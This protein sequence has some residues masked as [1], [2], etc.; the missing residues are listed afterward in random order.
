MYHH[1]NHFFRSIIGRLFYGWWIVI[2][3]ALIQAVGSGILYH[4][5]TVFFLPWKREFGASSVVISF[6][7]GA[8][9]LEGG[10]EG[11]AVGYLIDRFGPRALII[12]GAGLAGGGLILISRVQS[13]TAL[14]LIYVLVVSIGYNAGFLHPIS[15]AINSWFVRRRAIGFAIISAAGNLGGMIMAP[16]LSYILLN[17]GWRDGTL[18]AGVLI[19][20][21][22]LPSALLIH[23]SPE[24]RGLC[25]DGDAPK[26]NSA[27][28]TETPMFINQIRPV[29]EIGVKQAIKNLNYWL[30]FL[31][32]SLRLLVTVGLAVHFIPILVW[33]GMRESTSAYLLGLFSFMNIFAMLITGWV[34]DKMNKALLCCA[35]ILPSVFGMLG[36]VLSKSILFLYAFPVGLAITMGTAPLNW[37]LIGDLF[38]RRTFA[39]LRGIMGIGYG[40]ATFFSPIFA[41]WVF[42]RTSSYAIVLLTFLIILLVAASLF[43]ALY[44]RSLDLKNS[45]SSN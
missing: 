22:S 24:A 5:L 34:G 27:K 11:P 30:L 10:A 7:F 42:D 25:P 8:A 23:R 12:I 45:L 35:G 19:L 41:G 20:I 2:L 17:F 13:F 36:L 32:I 29:V 3:G 1:A 14:F 33:K 9:R 39:T 6:L 28:H 37:S 38:G 21:V 44:H 40:V 4:S 26:N 18:F 43:F 16:L 15:T 31:G